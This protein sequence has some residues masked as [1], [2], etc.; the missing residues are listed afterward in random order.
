MPPVKRTVLTLVAVAAV[1]VTAVPAGAKQSD[2]AIAK[3]GLIRKSDLGPGWT[4]KKH[5]DSKPSGVAACK[6]TEAVVAKTKKYRQSS[7]DFAQGQA[8]LIQNTVSVFPKPAQAAAFLAP[9]QLETTATC[10]QQGAEK[11]LPGAAVAVQPLDLSDAIQARSG[12]V[13]D[14]VGYEL[15]VTAPQ[16]GNPIPVE[17]YF[18]AVA[19]RSG[20]AV[21][22]YTF[23]SQ[24]QPFADVDTVVDATLTRLVTALG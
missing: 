24:D 2:S 17:V 13:D 3:Q 22:G 4:A 8:A 20:R 23:Q 16:S 10:L 9:Y 5:K 11:N 7:P 21:I 18:I 6:P 14:A 12:T 15:H 19:L 1:L